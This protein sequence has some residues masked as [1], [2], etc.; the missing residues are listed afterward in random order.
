MEKKAVY[1]SGFGGS[2]TH[3]QRFAAAV[4]EVRAAGFEV[5]NTAPTASDVDSRVEG[6]AL[7]RKADAVYFAPGW[8]RG[9]VGQFELSFCKYS[10]K[11]FAMGIAELQE[12]LK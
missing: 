10:G 2:E 11:P 3:A 8:N 6:L 7:L 12:V 4:D 5:L 9:I 1:I